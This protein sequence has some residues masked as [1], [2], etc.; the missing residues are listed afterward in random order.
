MI[1]LGQSCV[2]IP[3]RG[4]DS[5]LVGATLKRSKD[6]LLQEEEEPLV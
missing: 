1:S 4:S 6:G 5:F 3:S 2:C